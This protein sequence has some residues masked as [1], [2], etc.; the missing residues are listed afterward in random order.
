MSY[1]AAAVI[2][3]A[4]WRRL[5]NLPIEILAEITQLHSATTVRFVLAERHHPPQVF[6]V[7]LTSRKVLTIH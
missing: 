3:D 4:V 5:A 6:H 1:R 2:T 7:S